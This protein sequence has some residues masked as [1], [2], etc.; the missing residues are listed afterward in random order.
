QQGQ[1]PPGV[2]RVIQNMDPT[3]FNQ[4]YA[5]TQMEEELPLMLDQF[6]A[7]NPRYKSLLKR[8][9][10]KRKLYQQQYDE[11]KAKAKVAVLEE[12]QQMAESEKGKLE[13]LT[14]RVENLKDALGE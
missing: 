7:D 12:M 8:V 6:G 13:G 2:D 10:N 5:L 4:K 11:A 14:K 3:L 1:D 9:E